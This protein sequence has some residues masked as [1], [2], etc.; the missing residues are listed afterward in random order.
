MIKKKITIIPPIRFP[1]KI[2]GFPSESAARDKLISGIEV[3][4]PNK[5]KD[6]AKDDTFNFLE[7]LST[8]LIINPEPNQIAKK[9]I[10]KT[11]RFI[12]V[13]INIY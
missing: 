8:D 5:K 9:L 6:I 13:S 4:I 3:R 1:T 12:T 11:A 7:I 10:I 2:S